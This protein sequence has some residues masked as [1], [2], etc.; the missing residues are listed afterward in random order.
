MAPGLYVG[1]VIGTALCSY[2]LVIFIDP[3]PGLS[4]GNVGE[5]IGGEVIVAPGLSVGGGG[6]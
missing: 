3:S 6:R 2:S 4:I 1:G 5:A